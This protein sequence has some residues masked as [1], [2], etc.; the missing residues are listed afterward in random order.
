M[1]LV[2]ISFYLS[3][4]LMVTMATI[5]VL[6]NN[7]VRSVLALVVCFLASS[8]VWLLAQAEFLALI[9]I[10]VYVGAVMTLFLFV[11]MML[12]INVIAKR[13]HFVRYVPLAVFIVVLLV[14]LMFMV[15]KP[16]H[17]SLPHLVGN[18]PDTTNTVDNSKALG[19]ILYTNYAYAF[20]VA[21]V[22]L[23]VAIIAAITLAHRP[24][25]HC[26]TQD[27]GAQ[28]RVRREDRVRLVSMKSE[29]QK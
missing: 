3:A 17:F 5:V 14:G 11:I 22:L 13:S 16:E 6:S 15:I 27:I 29:S 2:Q 24:P 10:L 23:L 12:D 1:N 18:I 25:R 4:L 26:K 28:L 21:G 19:I 7:P 8:V 9:L 20:E